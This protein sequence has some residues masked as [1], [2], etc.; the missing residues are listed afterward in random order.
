M[1]LRHTK[2]RSRVK[3]AS[4]GRCIRLLGYDQVGPRAG[5]KSVPGVH[6]TPGT[7]RW[8]GGWM[9]RGVGNFQNSPGR[10]PTRKSALRAARPPPPAARSRHGGRMRPEVGPAFQRRSRDTVPFLLGVRLAETAFGVLNQ[11]K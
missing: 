9:A 7:G 3:G 4:G 6:C 10:I 8:M 1:R 5:G 2:R 11:K